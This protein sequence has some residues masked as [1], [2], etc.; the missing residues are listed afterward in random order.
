ML[1]ELILKNVGPAASMALK[2]GERINLLTGDNGAGKTFLLDI[3]WWAL[4]GTW[5]AEVNANLSSGMMAKPCNEDQASIYYKFIINKIINDNTS[6]F[7]R[8]E[9]KWDRGKPPLTKPGVSIYVQVDGS[10]SIFDPTRNSRFNLPPAYVF[11]QQEVW[12]GLED[13]SGRRLCN[14]LIADWANWQKENGQA[15]RQL[16]AVLEALSPASDERIA[17][18]ELTRIRLDDARD[19]PTLRMPYGQDVPVLHASSG[20]R[21]IIAL[22]YL[23]IWAW[24]EHVLACKLLGV[25]RVSDIVFLVDEIECHLHPKWQRSIIRSLL[26]VTQRLGEMA[27][28]KVQMI[29]STHS[30]LI[31]ASL[32]PY[33]DP[34][35]DKWFDIDLVREDPLPPR[36]EI[37]EQPFTRR[38]DAAN[39]L[40][41]KAFDLQSALSLEA[42]EA[43][44]EAAKVLSDPTAT[45]SSARNLEIKLREVLG[46]TDPFW[47]RWRFVM[48][49]KGWNT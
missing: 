28:S 26:N 12:H 42:E 35:R 2:F 9:Q 39:W 45:A 10:F 32:E 43:L 33:F 7:N 5:P 40:T 16:Q 41:S 14:G 4:T 8:I 21:R 24:Q 27:D 36:I 11:T 38:G 17:I 3:A 1:T 13:A 15:F 22:A 49:K 31:L 29:L 30:P 23:L 25:P 48:E 18:G 37:T 44:A 47:V 46:D 6:Y 20:L 19:I 34:N